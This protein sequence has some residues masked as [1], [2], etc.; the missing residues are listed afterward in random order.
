MKSLTPQ[1]LP[2]LALVD[3]AKHRWVSVPLSGSKRLQEWMDRLN[4]EELNWESDD[5]D[6]DTE[7][8][9]E[10]G[11]WKVD[12]KYIAVGVAVVVLALACVI[13]TRS[14]TVKEERKE[15]KED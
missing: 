11:G 13:C 10:T 9:V 2:K 14:K 6:P 1:N 3:L 4:L 7:E 15:K 12:I 8:P 5:D